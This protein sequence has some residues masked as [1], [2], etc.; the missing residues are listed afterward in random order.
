MQSNTNKKMEASDDRYTNALS[1]EL[2][3]KLQVVN[4]AGESR[5][6]VHEFPADMDIIDIISKIL[7]MKSSNNPFYIVDLHEIYNKCNDWFTLIPRAL[8]HYAIKSNPDAIIVNLLAKLGLGVDCASKD[9][10]ILA[11]SAGVPDEKI[12][13][14]NPCKDTE[15]LQYARSEDVDYLTFDCPNELDKIKVF[16]PDAQL[17]MRI[18]VNDAGSTC[19]FSSKFGCSLDEAKDLFALAQL[20]ELNIVGVSFHV[21][22]G[23]KVL[24]QFDTAISD[25]RK[26]FD[27]AKEYKFSL[28]ILDLGGG[29]P[30]TDEGDVT[31]PMLAKEINSA[32]DKYFSDIPDLKVISEP[33]RHLCGS[34]HTL[35]VAI[36]GIKSKKNPETGEKEY[37]YT[38]NDTIYGSF[39]CIIFDYSSPFILPY[40]ERTE[41][42]YKSM[43]NGASCDSL[44]VITKQKI[45][46]P[47]LAVGDRLYM[48][49]FG[50]YTRASS[51]SFNGFKTSTIHYITR[52]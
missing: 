7:E 21:G 15:S 48:R 39:N 4:T 40:N 28:N 32:I 30:S 51:S 31:F 23:C 41:K 44:D 3:D 52:V 6:K 50:S 45:D 1:V 42:T 13:Y 36:I 18:K 9:E 47:K 49:N 43:I 27:I 12:L 8:P 29:F 19:Q 14:A 34:S 46:L 37:T 35:V 10:I 5:D 17:I 11:K 2:S 16:H 26:V 22:S 20:D 38:I 24:G 33:G 25:A